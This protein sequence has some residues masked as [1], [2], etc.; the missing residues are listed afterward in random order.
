MPSWFHGIRHAAILFPAFLVMGR[1]NL[2][3][4]AIADDFELAWWYSGVDQGRTDSTGALHG[5]R[6][7][8]VQ[9]STWVRPSADDD[10][11]RRMGDQILGSMNNCG[12]R[13][14]RDPGA[15]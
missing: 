1:A 5:E 9:R 13:I 4:L 12:Q 7:V 11:D 6:Q 15:A 3:R 2:A 8:V 10:L 14:W